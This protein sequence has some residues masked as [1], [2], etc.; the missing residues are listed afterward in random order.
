MFQL[1][2]LSFELNNVAKAPSLTMCYVQ[3]Q[4]RS[5]F[6]HKRVINVKF[7]LPRWGKF[8]KLV[9][10]IIS[11]PGVLCI[12]YVLLCILLRDIGSRGKLRNY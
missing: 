7:F 9:N 11:K 2:K 10:D 1:Q 3:C 6:L 5:L 8:F 4:V 12:L